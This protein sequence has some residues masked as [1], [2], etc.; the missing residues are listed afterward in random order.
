MSICRDLNLWD[1]L[2]L[3]GICSDSSTPVSYH[4][5]IKRGRGREREYREITA[6]QEDTG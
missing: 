4:T 3:V 5:I 2:Q 6:G 1:E